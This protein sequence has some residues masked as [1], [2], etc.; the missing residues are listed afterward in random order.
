VVTIF[1][2]LFLMKIN[3]FYS[4]NKKGFTIIEL[5]VTV[6]IVAILMTVVVGSFGSARETSRDSQRQT[7][8]RTVEAAL[9][10]YQNKYGRYPEACNN[11]TIS[12][13]NTAIL[14]GQRDTNHECTDGTSQ[15][16]KGLAPEF[17]PKL[18]VDPKLNGLDSGYVYA[19]NS[20]GSV[21]KFMALKTVETE[22]IDI[23]SKWFRCDDSWDLPSNGATV[24]YENNQICRNTP[25]LITSNAVNPPAMRPCTLSSEYFSTYSVSGGFSSND[26]GAPVPDRGREYD[27]E[28]VRCG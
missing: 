6:S 8:L 20:E 9:A 1:V 27:T 18:P 5:L 26:L 10:L 16:I 11:A 2:D 21:Y 14:S 4:A 13:G 7:D 25:E 24:S 12:R 15:Y 19:V 3:M 22:T 28:I 23:F 17:I